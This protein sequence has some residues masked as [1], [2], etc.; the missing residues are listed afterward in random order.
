MTERIWATISVTCDRCGDLAEGKIA[1]TNPTSFYA[2]LRATWRS[3]GAVFSGSDQGIDL[4]N[5]CAR[6]LIDW[7]PR[8]KK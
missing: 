2:N 6:S 3:G 5:V 4:C 8:G 7:L 1:E